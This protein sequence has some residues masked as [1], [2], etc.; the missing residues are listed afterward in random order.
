MKCV[1]VCACTSFC[2]L[3]EFAEH[4]NVDG[5]DVNWFSYRKNSWCYSKWKMSS[6]FCHRFS[7]WSKAH[8]CQFKAFHRSEKIGVALRW[9]FETPLLKFTL[10]PN[11]RGRQ[12]H[13]EMEQSATLGW[14]EAADIKQNLSNRDLSPSRSKPVSLMLLLNTTFKKNYLQIYILILC[15]SIASFLTEFDSI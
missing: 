10:W 3:F 7:A 6:H 8:S 14:H 13:H 5:S 15:N 4:W 11:L 9:I 12:N 1:C 2:F